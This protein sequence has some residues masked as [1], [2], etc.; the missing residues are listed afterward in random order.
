[1]LIS[2]GKRR[3]YCDLLGSEG[4]PVVCMAHAMSSDS[5]IWAEQVPALLSNGWRVLRIDMRGHGG[6]DPVPGDYAMAELADD[7]ILVLDALGFDRVHYVG[8][9]IGGMVG[10]VLALDHRERLI[11][12]MLCATS[13]AA[14]P[15]GMAMW[16]K[17]FDLIEAA[18][19]IEAIADDTMRRWFTD[20]YD[21]R[22]R[23][24]QVR[25]TVS[26]ATTLGY[27]GGAAAIIAFDITERLP[28]ITTP[29]LV[30]CGDDDPGTPAEG[31]R[32]IAELIPGARYEEIAHARHL[33]NVQH[34]D[35]FNRMM[36]D[37][38]SANR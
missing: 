21:N 1:M 37:W 9:S 19:S 22:H 28:T 7:I 5:T 6:S 10:Q 16:A 17:R 23:I 14:V 33:L 34:P 32:R 38:L 31:N 11:S 3:I 12:A 8:L 2:D 24:A 30:V 25:S 13:S 36:L 20:D 27:R 18:G 29:T 4:D 35:T 15:G 26:N